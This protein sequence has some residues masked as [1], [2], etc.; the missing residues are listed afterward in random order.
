MNGQASIATFLW[1][2][3]VGMGVHCGWGLIE[4]LV[5]LAAKAVN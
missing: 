5:I 2:V 1:A 3:V 4:L